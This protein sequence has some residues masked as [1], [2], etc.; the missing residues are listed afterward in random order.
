MLVGAVECTKIKETV[1]VRPLLARLNGLRN[2]FHDVQLGVAEELFFFFRV[3]F[4]VL[5]C[6]VHLYALALGLVFASTLARGLVG[7][8]LAG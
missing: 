1:V 6:A 2:F 8:V 5:F 4:G 7:A 3:L